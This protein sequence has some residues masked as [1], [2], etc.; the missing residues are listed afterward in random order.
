MN[1]PDNFIDKLC[2]EIK[3]AF[4]IPNSKNNFAE[5]EVQ[6]LEKLANGIAKRKMAA[7]AIMFLET[8]KPMGYIGSQ[9]MV[10][11]RPFYSLVFKTADYDKISK[12][13]EKR[14]C[15]SKLIKLLENK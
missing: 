13:L 5:E 6:L 4:A 2:K 1:Q 7:P 12:V 14:E 11:F 9:A 8:L 10:F 3:H 15:T